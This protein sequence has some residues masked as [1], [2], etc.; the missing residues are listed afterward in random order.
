MTRLQSPIIYFDK[1]ET[2]IFSTQRVYNIEVSQPLPSVSNMDP[3]MFLPA[4]NNWMDII[5]LPPHLQKF[6]AA[7]LLKE[8]KEV[9]KKGTF[10]SDTP[11]SEDPI[12]PVTA[13]FRVKLTTDGTIDKLK[14]RIALRGDLMRD[15]VQTPDTWC[16]I[17]S[18]RSFK[19]FLAMAARWRQR[20]FQLDYVA[21]FLQADVIGRKFTSLPKEWKDLFKNNTEV[22]QYLGTPLR[23][24]KLF[25]GDRVANLAW[26]ETQSAWLT[27]EEIGFQ[28]LPSD[29]SIYIKRTDNEV[30]AVLRSLLY[31][32]LWMT[33][34]TLLPTRNSRTGLNK[35]Q[36]NAS[37]CR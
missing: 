6:W 15:N 2:P 26:D 31:S 24:N 16:P 12:I 14:S 7:S 13:K 23:L 17:A 33:N 37:M 30:I 36:P 21:A 32:T 25:Y 1:W 34:F 29:G 19:I 9:I 27:S 35:L 18:F 20:I 4:P 22:H 5:K 8:L 28:R 3:L 10:I 11:T